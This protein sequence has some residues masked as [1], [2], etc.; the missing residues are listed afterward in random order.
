VV[1]VLQLYATFSGSPKG[2]GYVDK[3][4]SIDN[5]MFAKLIRECGLLSRHCTLSDVDVIFAKVLFFMACFEEA[6]VPITCT[7]VCS[8][9][10]RSSAGFIFTS[11]KR[12]LVW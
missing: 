6:L 9:N 5:A 1:L 11:F 10:I 3:D 8:A 4:V 12:H 7:C 2:S